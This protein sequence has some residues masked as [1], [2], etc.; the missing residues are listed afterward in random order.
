MDWAFDINARGVVQHRRTIRSHLH[1]NRVGNGHW[2]A[3]RHPDVLSGNPTD[4]HRD[5]GRPFQSQTIDDLGQS[6]VGRSCPAAVA[7]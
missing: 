2:S 4:F 6:V 1:L 7:S 5:V 3:V